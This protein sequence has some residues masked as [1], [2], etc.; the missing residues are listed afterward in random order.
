VSPMCVSFRFVKCGTLDLGARHVVQGPVP[1]G[2]PIDA[3]AT[4]PRTG[5]RERETVPFDAL[6]ASP[7]MV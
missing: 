4:G 7:M 5:S 1:A 3:C 6:P 2:V